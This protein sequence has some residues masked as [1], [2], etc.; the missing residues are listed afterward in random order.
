LYQGAQA[1]RQHF[2][3]IEMQG[4]VGGGNVSFAGKIA[5]VK[6]NVAR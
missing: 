4:I 1:G 5:L 3:A 6:L 2:D